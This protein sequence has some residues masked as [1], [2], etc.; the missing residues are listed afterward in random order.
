[1][2]IHPFQSAEIGHIALALS[3]AQAEFKPI[4]KNKEVS[5]MLK[6][7]GSRKYSYAELDSILDTVRPSLAK[8]Q[9]CFHQSE[10]YLD[11]KHFLFTQL[12]HES[13]QWFGSYKALN[14]RDNDDQSYGSSMSYQRRYSAIAILGIHPEDDDD[15]Q[16]AQENYK[17]KQ[18]PQAFQGAP[19]KPVIGD[20][21]NDEQVAELKKAAKDNESLLRTV[22]S[23][24]NIKE[25]A[26][27]PQ[28]KYAGSLK[29]LKDKAA[30]PF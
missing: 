11:G 26:H 22:L 5:M 2:I 18:Y 14:P 28:A 13:G 20:L 7:G 24:N 25:L 15:A 3:K 1:M 6:N 29:W 27:M 4:L 9:I 10:Q 23:F 19:E 30:L 17:A 16:A 21:I 8:Y 12:S